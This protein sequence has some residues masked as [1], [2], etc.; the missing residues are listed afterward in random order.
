[1]GLLLSKHVNP[2]T[3]KSA[4]KFDQVDTKTGV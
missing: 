3:V 1:M 4:L 2:A